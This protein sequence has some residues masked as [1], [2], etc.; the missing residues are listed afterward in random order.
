MGDK[1]WAIHI[2]Y[3]VGQSVLIKVSL[4]NNI[5]GGDVLQEGQAEDCSV[6]LSHWFKDAC[7]CQCC[8]LFAFRPHKVECQ[9][10]R[11]TGCYFHLESG[12]SS[13]RCCPGVLAPALSLWKK[14]LPSPLPSLSSLHPLLPFLWLLL[15]L[16]SCPFL[17]LL[18]FPLVLPPSSQGGPQYV[19]HSIPCLVVVVFLI[20]AKMPL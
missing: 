2:Y 9:S 3:T 10:L 6:S 11:V 19:F 12:R 1:E 16:S 15:S 14:S 20:Y 7:F 8:C 18:T 5:L 13:G 4:V 17:S